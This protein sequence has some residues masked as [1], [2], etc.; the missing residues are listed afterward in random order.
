MT[1]VQWHPD[2]TSRLGLTRSPTTQGIE[3]RRDKPSAR[4]CPAQPLYW[5]FFIAVKHDRDG[6][7]G[8]SLQRTGEHAGRPARHDQTGFQGHLEV[9][10]FQR[11]SDIDLL[12]LWPW[13]LSSPSERPVSSQQCL[14]GLLQEQTTSKMQNE[15]K[16][17]GLLNANL[18]VQPSCHAWHSCGEN[19]ND[20]KEKN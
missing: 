5:W 1:G 14:P 20:K 12:S 6:S 11:Q 13:I 19:Q 15:S 8:T 18:K 3:C 4:F 16:Q 2:Q 9:R 7:T 17:Q 10:L